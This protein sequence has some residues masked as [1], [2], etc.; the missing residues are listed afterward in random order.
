MIFIAKNNLL[1]RILGGY[2]GERD[3]TKLEKRIRGS[4]ECDP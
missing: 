1:Y 4:G 2:L 3:I